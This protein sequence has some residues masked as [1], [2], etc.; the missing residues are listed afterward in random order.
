MSTVLNK[1]PSA[2]RWSKEFYYQMG[3][4]GWFDGKRVELIDGEII[5]MSPIGS[6]HATAVM[7]VS[8]VLNAILPENYCVNVQNPLN[9]GKSSEPVPDVSVLP[10]TFRDYADTLPTDSAL[11][12]E[13]ADSSL[14]YDSTAKAQ[15]Y[16][17]IG[18]Q[19]F[20]IV[21]LV[22]NRLIVHRSP[23]VNANAIGRPGYAQINMFGPEATVSPL[24]ALGAKV[25][26]A[27][28]LP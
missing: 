26:V 13:V 17:S 9:S 10:G 16:A 2:I 24:F 4:L 23:E 5:E 6:R 8:Q 12:V 22:G 27:S 3:E 11:V 19:E 1:P 15:L 28:L 20:W 18:I 25:E 21:D 14:R 7:L